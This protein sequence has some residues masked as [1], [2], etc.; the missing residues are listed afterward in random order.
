MKYYIIISYKYGEKEVIPFNN[1][2]DMDMAYL[3]ILKDDEC[4]AIKKIMKVREVL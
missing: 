2:K 3:N 4:S 1:R